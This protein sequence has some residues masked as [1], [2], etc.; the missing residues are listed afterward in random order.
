M[1]YIITNQDNELYHYGVRGM[2]WG[3]RRAQKLYSKSTTQEGRD[4]AISMLQKHREKSSAKVDKLNKK[5]VK[6]EKKVNKHI[7]KTDVKAA[8]LQM[9]SAK[10][11]NK[12]YGT[13]TSRETAQKRL[14]KADKMDARIGAMKARSEQAKAKI[15]KNENLTKMFNQGINNIDKTLSEAG[16]RYVN[17]YN[18]R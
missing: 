17:G 3:V 15:A 5:H 9:K 6:L 1:E 10:I 18:R 13:F 4:K 11:R 16:R 8:K 14:Y 7:Q 2:K 12:A